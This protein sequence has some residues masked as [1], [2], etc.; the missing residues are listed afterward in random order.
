MS[1]I[2]RVTKL[3]FR[4]L[5]LRHSL[6]RRANPRNVN[7]VV[8]SRWK[9][10]PFITL[11]L[12]SREPI[13]LKTN[14]GWASRLVAIGRSQYSESFSR[15]HVAL[16]LGYKFMCIGRSCHCSFFFVSGRTLHAAYTTLSPRHHPSHFIAS[17]RSLSLWLKQRSLLLHKQRVE[18]PMPAIC[19]VIFSFCRNL[20]DSNVWR[21]IPLHVRIPG[22][23]LETRSHSTHGQVLPNTDSGYA[24]GTWREPIRPCGH[25]EDGIG[26]G[27]GRLVRQTGPCVQLRWGMQLLMVTKYDLVGVISLWFYRPHYM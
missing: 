9:R 18:S 7:F 23:C 25:R 1:T 3:M 20:L 19:Y 16:Q 24:H 26:Q 6:R 17:E 10:E 2:K 21:W 27:F 4:A 11:F 14:T 5:A 8:S 13:L 12:C 15:P 22:E